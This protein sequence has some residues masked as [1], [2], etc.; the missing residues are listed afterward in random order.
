[1]DP[2]LVYI[3]AILGG[4]GV[5]FCLCGSRYPTDDH[6]NA[7]RREVELRIRK[8]RK[9]LAE[10]EHRVRRAQSA[11]QTPWTND[12][13]ERAELRDDATAAR[14]KLKR[15]RVELTAL[16][17]SQRRAKVAVQPTL[18]PDV[19]TDEWHRERERRR[20]ELDV[21]YWS[22]ALQGNDPVLG[23]HPLMVEVARQMAE[24]LADPGSRS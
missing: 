2:F 12:P 11:A 1:M 8:L 15:V 24:Y 10:A 22:T 23:D 9:Q 5:V 14:L 18:T 3:I 13:R 21:R 16:T 7:H 20:R 6:R 4:C 17:A 19:L